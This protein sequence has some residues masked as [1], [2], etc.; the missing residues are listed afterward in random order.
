MNLPRNMPTTCH[1]PAHGLHCL[2]DPTQCSAWH[3]V[4][5]ELTPTCLMPPSWPL[6]ST[7][8]SM[9]TPSLWRHPWIVDVPSTAALPKLHSNA[10]VTQSFSLPLLSLLSPPPPSPSLPLPL[11]PSLPHSL[12]SSS[13]PLSNEFPEAFF[14]ESPVASTMPRSP[15]VA[16]S[17]CLKE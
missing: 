3:S 5:H 13:F 7:P 16:V 6:V 2:Q 1:C 10:T 9:S 12:S 14:S 4:P 15:E 8:Y 11:P 17:T